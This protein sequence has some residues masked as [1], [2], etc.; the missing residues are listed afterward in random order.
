METRPQALANFDLGHRWIRDETGRLSSTAGLLA[1]QESGFLFAETCVRLLRPGGRFALV[2]PNGY[3]GNRSQPFLV[4]REW[5]LR[6]CRLSVVIGLP[7]FTFK[8]S[9]ADV[10]ASVLFCEK[11]E[12]PLANASDSENYE[13]AVEVVDR[14]GWVTGDKNGLRTPSA[15]QSAP[16]PTRPAPVGYSTPAT[17]AP[18]RC[19][20]S[21]GKSVVFVIFESFC[22]AAGEQ[23]N[24]LKPP[25]SN[26]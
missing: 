3:L 16:T 12:T 9:G 7:R 23:A 25:S 21:C 24:E 2:V 22:I 26:Y 10:S 6:H 19:S 5:L 1:A 4:L 13:F 11:R 17:G 8:G 14:V 18:I 20:C 15:P